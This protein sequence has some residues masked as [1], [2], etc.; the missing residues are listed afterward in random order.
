MGAYSLLS[1]LCGFVKNIYII[2]EISNERYLYKFNAI[3]IQFQVAPAV[4]MS[5]HP[6]VP[7]LQF[8]DKMTLK[9]S[10]QIKRTSYSAFLST[11]NSRI[12]IFC[13]TNLPVKRNQIVQY[14]HLTI[15]MFFFC[16]KEICCSIVQSPW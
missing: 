16:Q 1:I 11:V 15:F 13:F 7:C 3:Q 5:P 10:V 2:Y 8:R 4:T 14:A 12:Q 9:F 6:N